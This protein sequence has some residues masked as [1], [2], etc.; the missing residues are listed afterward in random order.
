MRTTTYCV[1]LRLL[2]DLFR[3]RYNYYLLDYLF[4]YSISYLIMI[5]TKIIY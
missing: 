4:T 1:E 2:C 5:K 3:V